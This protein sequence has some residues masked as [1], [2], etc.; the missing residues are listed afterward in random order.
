MSDTP[1]ETAL[2]SSRRFF[3]ENGLGVL[4]KSLP[5]KIRLSDENRARFESA[6]GFDSAL[7]MPPPAVQ[8]KHVDK[9]IAQLL[10][11]PS[12]ALPASQQY[13]TEAW[14][15]NPPD[16]PEADLCNRPDMPYV[17]LYCSGPFPNAVLNQTSRAKLD[18][19][20]TSH[21]WDSLTF[22]EY[23]V[24]QRMI[25]EARGDHS[26]DDYSTQQLWLLDSRIGDKIFHAHWNGKAGRV[27]IGWCKPS[28][29]HGHRGAQP[30]KVI[31]LE[32]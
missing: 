21:Q 23:V 8:V 16:V 27:E 1:L 26:F 18:R 30:T 17:L 28:K 4:A 20:F 31:L 11:A 19:V 13:T 12:A 7:V 14:I 22:Y 6:E 10:N 3:V 5:R 2:K 24:L 15:L 25:A 29:R 9:M 32:G